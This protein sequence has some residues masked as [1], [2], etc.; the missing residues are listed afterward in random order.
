MKPENSASPPDLP[1]ILPRSE[2]AISR[3]RID[4]NTLKVL[5]RLHR[6]GFKA[7]L[8]GGGVRD[9]LL[10]RTPKDFD[11]GTDATPNQVKK[12]FRNCFLVG[13][14]FRLAHVRFGGNQLVEVATFRRQPHPDDLPEDPADHFLFTENV[15]GTPEEDAFRRDFTINALFYDIATFSVIDYV[16]G[17][18][19]LAARRLRVIGPPRVRFTEDPVRMLRALEFTARLG[20]SLDD[21]TREGVFECAP[22][23]AEAAPAR[24]RE[25]VM[26]LFRHRVAAPVL[27]SAQAMGLLP[28]LLAGFEGDRETFDLLEKVDERTASGVAI[29]ESFALAAL[30]LSRFRRACPSDGEHTVTDAVR[31]AGLVLAPHSNYFH[32]AHGIRHQARELLVGIFRLLRGPGQRG[33]RRFLQHPATP[34]SLALFTLWV[35]VSGEGADLLDPWQKALARAAEPQAAPSQK[36]KTRRTRRGGRRRGRGGRR[37][38]PSTKS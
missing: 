11:V 7:F 22:L 28:H 16:G 33:E 8:V 17:L 36:P 15:F 23:I 6:N 13:R 32:V 5:Y 21:A 3:K 20:F 30:Y 4:E 34:R 10:N 29:E 1:V 27:N 24:I 37:P 18:E 25:E 31:I 19:D 38:P 35:G 9:L 2:H 14:R 26:E 12:L